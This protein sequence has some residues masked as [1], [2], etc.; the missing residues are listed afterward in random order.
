MKKYFIIAA[1]ALVSLSASAQV[2]FGIK[3]GFVSSLGFD[4]NWTFNAENLKIKTD[5]AYG[6]DAGLMLRAG[7]RFYGQV[8]L[9]YHFVSSLNEI[10]QMVE[11]TFNG[12][13]SQ[14]ITEQS[15]NIP[16]MAGVKLVDTKNFNLRLMVGPTFN[17]NIGKDG[18]LSMD[19]VD[20]KLNICSFGLDC[21]IGMDIWVFSLDAR[22]RLVQP[23]YTYKINEVTMNTN[24]VNSFEVS[25]GW[26]IFDYT[27]R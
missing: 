6:F 19:G 26:K 14:T 18:A 2:A 7:Y 3:A 24:P 21:G 5:Q 16:V 27:K 1:L 15:I 11:D 20:S 12:K 17:F 13:K 23:G 4:Q 8:E 10:G 22:Y 25:L 9:N